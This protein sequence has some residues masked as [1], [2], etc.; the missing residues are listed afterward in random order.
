[1]VSTVDAT[2][3][4]RSKLVGQRHVNE[5]VDAAAQHVAD[6]PT[7]DERTDGAVVEDLE[8]VET[9]VD[10]VTEEGSPGG[11]GVGEGTSGTSFDVP[12]VGL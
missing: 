5:K 6:L 2:D 8:V 11:M 1:M 7:E 12:G 3:E 10:D 4:S 9:P